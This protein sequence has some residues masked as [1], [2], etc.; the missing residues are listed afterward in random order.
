MQ[1][2]AFQRR[3]VS[4]LHSRF[5]SLSR[6]HAVLLYSCVTFKVSSCSSSSNQALPSVLSLFALPPLLFFFCPLLFSLKVKK[7]LSPIWLTS[8]LTERVLQFGV[9]A[10]ETLGPLTPGP[11]RRTRTN[12]TFCFYFLQLPALKGLLVEQ[13]T[14]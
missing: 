14:I 1:R 9:P 4:P 11:T 3:S 5:A 6:R 7:T 12:Q 8:Q 2:E 10:A 13:P